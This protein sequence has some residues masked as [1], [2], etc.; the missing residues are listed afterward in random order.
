MKRIEDR[1]MVKKANSEKKCYRCDKELGIF[2]IKVTRDD[3]KLAKVTIPEG[4]KSGDVIC[5]R[6]FDALQKLQEDENIKK[7]VYENVVYSEQKETESHDKHTVNSPKFCSQCGF[8]IPMES[9][10]CS[11]CGS[12]KLPTDSTNQKLIKKSKIGDKI[13][14]ILGVFMLLLGVASH[15]LLNILLGSVIFIIGFVSLKS[16]TKNVQQF[17]AIVSCI[18][19]GVLIINIVTRFI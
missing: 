10:Y 1:R 17:L 8:L 14:M 13:Q 12:R 16:T 5:S 11:K 6:C 7:T 3:M 4:M 2:L 19:A 9:N 18:I 15:N